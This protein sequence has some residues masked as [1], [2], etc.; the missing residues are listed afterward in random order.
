MI[1]H[2]WGDPNYDSCFHKCVEKHFFEFTCQGTHNGL[3]LITGILL[4]LLG[5]NQVLN[6]SLF[7]VKLVVIVEVPGTQNTAI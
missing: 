1:Q 4:A 6:H 7:S 2:S 5:L 3:H